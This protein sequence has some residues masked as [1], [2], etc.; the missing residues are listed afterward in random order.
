MCELAQSLVERASPNKGRK[1]IVFG[2]VPPLRSTF[3]VPQHET[4]A[5]G[6]LEIVD[7]DAIEERTKLESKI[8]SDTASV[9]LGRNSNGPN[10]VQLPHKDNQNGHN[11]QPSLETNMKRTKET[12][13]NVS[14]DTCG[15]DKAMTLNESIELPGSTPLITE[16]LSSSKGSLPSAYRLLDLKLQYTHLA[17]M[18]LETK[19]QADIELAAAE[20]ACSVR[21]HAARK[22]TRKSTDLGAWT[23]DELTARQGSVRARGGKNQWGS[24]M[25]ACARSN[26]VHPFRA[27]TCRNLHSRV[28]WHR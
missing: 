22:D 7:L 10:V 17:E 21:E 9:D 15:T 11:H 25:H 3:S 26:E 6:Q 4:C 13:R 27:A 2:T 19:I 8:K 16:A 12:K 14:Q 23:G 24:S 1:P 18:L 28:S 20:R 5:A